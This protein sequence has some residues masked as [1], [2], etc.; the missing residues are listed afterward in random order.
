MN[1]NR[2]VAS[3]RFLDIFGSLSRKWWRPV[4]PWAA[5]W[6]LGEP[7]ECQ[8]E[9]NVGVMGV[10]CGSWSG[11]RIFKSFHA[12]SEMSV[13]P[14]K[15]QMPVVCERREREEWEQSEERVEGER[16]REREE[17]GRE[18][19][20]CR[21]KEEEKKEEREEGKGVCDLK[22]LRSRRGKR[23]EGKERCGR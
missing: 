5:S 2:L 11:T 9:D 15:I 10:P 8:G 1:L 16:E 12:L 21:V 20:S 6:S 17:V 13:C 19:G 4:W 22:V 3:H 18:N 23:R 7:V 14:Y